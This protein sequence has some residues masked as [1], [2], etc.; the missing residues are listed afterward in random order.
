[1]SNKVRQP[2]WETVGGPQKDLVHFEVGGAF[3]A[4]VWRVA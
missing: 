4:C 1:M 2:A 3:W